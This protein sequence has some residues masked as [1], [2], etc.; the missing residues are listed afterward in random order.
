L[1][2]STLRFYRDIY[3][4]YLKPRVGK[5]KLRDFKTSHAQ[6]VLDSIDL[7]H[8]TLLR[9]KTCMSAAFTVAQQKDLVA[10][11]PIG[12]AK[13]EGKRKRFHGYAYTLKEIKYM[14]SVLDGTAR[15]VVALAA[16]T[17][18]REGE[19][20]GLRWSDY[21]GDILNV[22]RAIWRTHVG[23][24]KTED[25]ESYVPVI[26]PLRLIL[27]EH[28]RLTNGT[29]GYIFA[30]PK[31]NFALNLDNLA[32]RE[33]K[34]VLGERWHGY[35]AFRRGLATDMFGLG[36]PAEVSQILLR[37]ADAATTR[38]HYLKLQGHKQGAAAMKQLEGAIHKAKFGQGMGN[39]K[40]RDS[41]S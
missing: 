33:I 31:K 28:K 2:K 3:K 5:V 4:L 40:K 26:K 35:H 19:I 27:D 14:L 11:N 23:L 39:S 13:A 6:A 41:A 15:T 20:R 12:A 1:T 37:H 21:A 36:V 25:S 17:G 16:F 34:P 18:M 24:P 9:I 38:K 8:Q 30:G 29:D 7:S 22:N 10:V 32:K